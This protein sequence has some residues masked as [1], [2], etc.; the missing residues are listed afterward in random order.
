MADQ[1]VKA[2]FQN[3]VGASGTQS[4]TTY[5]TLPD[6]D[7]TAVTCGDTADVF[8]AYAQITS[9]VGAADVW[10][11]GAQL[12]ALSVADDA[13]IGF[14]TG[15]AG[16][17]ADFAVLPITRTDLSTVGLSY[18]QTVTLPMMIRIPSGTRLSAHG[19][20]GA[21]ST[22]VNVVAIVASSLVG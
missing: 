7:D 13:K 22:T 1:L 21:A 11:A 8:G 9:T 12:G 15:G 10:F 5:D 19:K 18:N 20:S 3:L 2:I 6:N 4:A 16:S 17:E 14:A